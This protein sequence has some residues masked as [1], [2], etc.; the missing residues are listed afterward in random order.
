MSFQEKLVF[1]MVYCALLLTSLI[2]ISANAAEPIRLTHSTANDTEACYSP[3]G[4]TIVF[5]SDRSGTLDLYTIDCHQEGSDARRAQLLFR[6]PGHACFPTFSSDGKSI[7]YAYAQ[8]TATARNRQGDGY[9]LF[10]ISADRQGL[11]IRLTSGPYR[12]YSPTFAP[13]GKS[14]YFNST[15]IGGDFAPIA[16]YR[17]GRQGGEPELVRQIAGHMVQATFSPD[18]RFVAYGAL[19][20]VDDIWT[21][22]ISKRRH[23]NDVTVQRDENDR[24]VWDLSAGFNLGTN[25]NGAWSYG[26][27]MHDRQ[28]PIDTTKLVLLPQSSANFKNGPLDAWYHPAVAAGLYADLPTIGLAAAGGRAGHIVYAAGEMA[29][30]PGGLFRGGTIGVTAVVRWTAPRVGTIVVMGNA[31]GIAGGDRDLHLVHNRSVALESQYSQN[32]TE[33][34]FEHKLQVKVGDTIDLCVGRGTSLPSSEARLDELIYYEGHAP[35]KEKG[36]YLPT[37]RNQD[38]VV[39]DGGRESF[40]APRWSPVGWKVACTGYRIGDNGWN[41]YVIDVKTGEK[42]C[43]TADQVGNSRSPT[44]SPDGKSIVYENN[45]SGKYQ[46]YRLDL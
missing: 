13:D 2:H 9:N 14:I 11:P 4:Q 29:A 35:V 31:R 33:L 7:V 8:F 17:V 30:H 36:V 15:R 32:A 40:Y 37:A 18:G 27:V 1:S 34:P 38:R 24:N 39:S 23:L 21:V 6:S 44:W 10:S 5:Q 46:L 19:R 22:R 41:I 16:T 25:P 3:D 26:Y 28:L 42:R 45:Q 20:G 12:D 43:L